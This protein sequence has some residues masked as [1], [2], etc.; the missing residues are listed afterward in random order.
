MGKRAAHGKANL[1]VE[2]GTEELPPRALSRLGLAFG[3]ALR[4]ALQESG[5]VSA[6]EEWHWY[7]TPRR[8]S[9]WIA[10]VARRQ[11]DREQE[12]RGPALTAAFDSGGKPTPAA[13]GFA[14]SCGVA[15]EALQQLKSEKGAWL[16]YRKRERGGSATGVVP[17]CI[18]QAIRKLPVP[19][20]MRWSDLDAEFVRPVHWMVVLHGADVIKTELLA[21]KSGRMTHGHRFHAP[22][23]IRLSHADRYVDILE[24]EGQ[25]IADFAARREQ[26]RRQVDRCAKKVNGRAVV[27]DDL[28]DEVTGLVEW[29][30]ALAGAFDKEFLK[31]PDEVLRSSMQDHQKYFPVV[32]SRGRLLPYFIA[33]SNIKSRAPARVRKGNERVLRA[34]LSDA[35]FFWDSDRK[36]KLANRRDALDAVLFHHKLGTV[37]DKSERIVALSMSIAPACGLDAGHSRRA[38]ELCK[39]DLVT[40]MVGEFPAL[41]GTMGRYYAQHDGEPADVARAI[42]EHYQPR[43]AG[44]AI[45]ASGPGKVVALADKLDTLVGIFAA[46]EA[47]SGDK[48]P[49]GLRRAALGVLRILIEGKL[50][51][52]LRELLDLAV[53]VL[54][55]NAITVP[56]GVGDQVFEFISERLTAYYLGKGF[57][58]EEISAVASRM[59]TQP[60]DFD[61]R[62]QA[63]SAFRKLPAAESLAAANKRIGNILRRSE[64][65]IPADVDRALFRDSAERK[66]AE[67]FAAMRDDVQKHF[68]AREYRPGL[69][70]LAKLRKFVDRFFDEVMVMVDD[71]A[72]RAN[73]LALLQQIHG[74]FLQV[75]DISKLQITSE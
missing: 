41:Q 57:S 49:Y 58:S 50:P 13:L 33:V 47:P 2:I 46:G 40:D 38:A 15:V 21:A 73:R 65:D 1:L 68:S 7:A 59:P 11:P 45:P 24:K 3:Q 70:Q 48:D 72:L 27:S 16:I 75:A 64:Q 31:V 52:D 25:V 62:L 67:T 30:Q 18:E 63:V 23:P 34:R 10:N 4:A 55:K 66:L 74:L 22:K 17:G 28:L 61:L 36:L 51:L 8:L 69:V 37:A 56:K 14:R 9:V 20:R 29:P 5:L 44:D 43:Y 26:V 35:R 53:E 19:K 32:S 71:P 12:R 6:Q 42:E 39:A 60:L 54:E